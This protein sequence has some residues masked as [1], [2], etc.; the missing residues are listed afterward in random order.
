MRALE[1]WN[2]VSRGKI[3]KNGKLLYDDIIFKKKNSHMPFLFWVNKDNKNKP[4]GSSYRPVHWWIYGAKV[5]KI[6][7]QILN[8]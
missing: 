2:T 5:K 6:Y 8:N 1:S 4:S 3:G 7:H